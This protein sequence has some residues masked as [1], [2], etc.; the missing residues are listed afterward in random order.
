[1]SANNKAVVGPMNERK[2]SLPERPKRRIK[3]ANRFLDEE[4]IPALRI[5]RELTPEDINSMLEDFQAR[6]VGIGNDF[7]LDHVWSAAWKRTLYLNGQVK[8][9]PEQ[10]LPM[11]TPIILKAWQLLTD[12][13]LSE[14]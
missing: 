6:N 7:T 5:G 2:T 11:D 13:E 10:A 14:G 12:I 9:H 3:F 8:N 4:L 1:M